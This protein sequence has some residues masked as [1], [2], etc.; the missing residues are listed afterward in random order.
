MSS[1]ILFRLDGIDKV[2]LSQI[3]K[4][5]PKHSIALM[6][7]YEGA[8][9]VVTRL[10][11]KVK[12]PTYSWSGPDSA[13]IESSDNPTLCYNV[14]EKM[15]QLS[16]AFGDS[17]VTEDLLQQF[18]SK[19]KIPKLKAKVKKTKPAEADETA[20][21]KTDVKVTTTKAG[22]KSTALFVMKD[23]NEGSLV[24]DPRNRA[25]HGKHRVASEVRKKSR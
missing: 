5:V 18:R 25:R 16:L 20:S 14:L 24:D 9:V 2:E 15:W 13:L 3:S 21:A 12:T 6:F 23:K 8:P 17:H 22:T 10:L 4:T 11:Q 7:M 19:Y 1:T